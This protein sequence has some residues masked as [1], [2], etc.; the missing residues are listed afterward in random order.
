MDGFS[1]QGTREK[2]I[3]I[4]RYLKDAIYAA[5]D[6][7]VTTFAV[8]AATVGG[9][10]SPATI[11]I[12]GIANL[13]ADGFSMASSN[14]L[15]SRSENDFYAREEA[16]ERREIEEKPGE[17]RAEIR[18]ILSRKGYEG[19]DLDL[20][21]ELVVSK[22]QMWL[23]LMMGEEL[24]LHKSGSVSPRHSAVLTLVS[25]VIA[26]SIPLLPYLILGKS[27]SFILAA[28]ST[29]AAL[30]GV[31]AARSWFSRIAT[32]TEPNGELTMRHMTHA[33]TST[34][35]PQRS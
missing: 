25:F 29:G 13:F 14:Y 7:I 24:G 30:F 32:S 16:E 21:L 28:A 9:A 1:N 6:G 33:T 4:G 17:E 23:D 11:L 22:E 8:V 20:L 27:A 12:V 15:G 10:L 26:G 19:Q 5:N 34:T 3:R 18:G 35:A 2:H 31:G